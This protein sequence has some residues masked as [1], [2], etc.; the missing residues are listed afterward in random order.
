MIVECPDDIKAELAVAAWLI[1]RGL[2]EHKVFDGVNKNGEII[3]KE[4]QDEKN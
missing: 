1:N 3:Y 2:V 4:V